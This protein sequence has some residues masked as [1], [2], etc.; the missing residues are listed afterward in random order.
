MT[1]ARFI[2]LVDDDG[3]VRETI[4]EALEE[5]GHRVTSAA[6]G[7][8]ALSLL[9]DGKVRP[10]L[11][12]LDIMMPE[13]DGWAFRA[14]QRKHPELAS[15]PVV[16]FTA[17]GSPRDAGYNEG[18]SYMNAGNRVGDYSRNSAVHGTG[19]GDASANVYWRW[20][21]LTNL[22]HSPSEVLDHADEDKVLRRVN[23]EPCS[24]RA[25]PVECIQALRR[26]GALWVHDDREI[27][28]EA[29]AFLARTVEVHLG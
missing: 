3:D 26:T 28:S 15:I 27:H 23:P 8:E 29:D 13:M 19:G 9:R 6:N 11:I 2:L 21:K 1:A 17:Y 22:V 4:R 24:E 25:A 5:E 20:R 12:L 14:E 7:Q 10:D 18:V 16:V